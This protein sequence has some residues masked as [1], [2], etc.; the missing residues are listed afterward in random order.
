MYT[1]DC[2]YNAQGVISCPAP[3][4]NSSGANTEAFTTGSTPLPQWVPANGTVS[5]SSQVFPVC[6]STC[7]NYTQSRSEAKG[8]WVFVNNS[9]YYNSRSKNCRC[10]HCSGTTTPCPK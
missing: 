2:L 3:D 9:I 6:N 10:V 5:S 1:Q 7:G 4:S 8:T